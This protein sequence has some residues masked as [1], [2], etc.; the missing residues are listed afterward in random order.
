MPRE[1]HH[2]AALPREE[3][4]MPDLQDD[5]LP[6]PAF[7]RRTAANTPKAP[8]PTPMKWLESPAIKKQMARDAKRKARIAARTPVLMAVQEG[9]DTVGKIRKKLEL[10]TPII[11]AA[12]RYLIKMHKVAKVGRWY[13]EF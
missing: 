8:E 10:E 4:I 3:G 13:V 12:L 7:L 6:I 11:L 2:E 5:N 9:V 1:T